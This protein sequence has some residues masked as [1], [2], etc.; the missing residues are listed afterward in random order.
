[1]NI[2]DVQ[3]EIDLHIKRINAILPDLGY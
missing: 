3:E 1:M 2:E